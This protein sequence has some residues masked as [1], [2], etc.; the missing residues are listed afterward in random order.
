MSRI[1]TK[2][3]RDGWVSS[4]Q[5]V[6]RSWDEFKYYCMLYRIHR[7]LAYTSM[8]RCWANNPVMNGTNFMTSN[9]KSKE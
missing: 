6:Y 7:Q 3:N 8:K 1:K 9:N 5:Q 4:V 2:S